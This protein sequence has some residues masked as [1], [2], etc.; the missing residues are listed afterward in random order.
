MEHTVPLQDLT[1]LV[2]PELERA[3]RELARDLAPGE[4]DLVP[5]LEHVG[6]FRG[7][8]IRPA[9]VLLAG[10]AAGELTA[11]HVTVAKVVELI[12]TATLVH[13][14]IL[15]GATLRRQVPTLHALHGSE[16]SVLLGDYLYAR[17]FQMAVELEDQACS[18]VLAETTR[19]IC[20]GEVTQLLHRFDFDWTEQRYEKVIADKTASLF[21]AAARLGAHY[22]GARPEVVE[23]LTRYGRALG[24]AFQIVD[25][26]LD[27]SGEE[28]VVGK[29]LGSDLS[30]GKLTLPLLYLL[31]NERDARARLRPMMG[32]ENGARRLADEFDLEAALDFS[33]LRARE[34]VADATRAL[35]AVPAGVACDALHDLAQYVVR[36]E[37]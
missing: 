18:R 13:D 19:V 4:P 8:Q 28:T 2:Q 7:K 12:H 37:L 9:L 27:V 16:V 25:D 3:N 33:L 30:E 21:A 20:Q 14:D 24:I 1:A 26:C 17:A 35:A 5:L 6:H 15:D 32:R 23:G 11:A 36:R 34:H 31:Q 10:R 22:A 29:S